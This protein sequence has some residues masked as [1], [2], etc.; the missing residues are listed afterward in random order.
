[1]YLMLKDIEVLYFNLDDFIV[2]EIRPDLV[3]FSLR[4]TFS[5]LYNMKSLMKNTQLL[6]TYLSR[7]VLS[8]SRTNAKQIYALFGIPQMDD[9][10]TR[11]KICL[12]CMGVSIQDSYWVKPDNSNLKF[13]DVNIRVN[14][15][16]E[17]IDISLDGMCPSITV[18]CINPELTTHGV[19]RKAWTRYDDG[20][21]LLK[22]DSHSQNIN[23]RMEVL[24]SKILDCFSNKI[25]CV[26]YDGRI[27]NTSYGKIYTDKCKSYAR[28]THSAVEAWEIMEYTSRQ[29]LN[30]RDYILGLS[31]KVA[32]IGV[33]DFIL[34]NTDRHTQ[35]YGFFMNNSTGLIEDVVP[36]FDFNL[37]LVSDLLGVDTSNV[38]S[39]MFNDD[40]T[41]LD[42]ARYYRPLTSIKL[43]KDKLKEIKYSNKEYSVAIDNVL[44]RYNYLYN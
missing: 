3:P 32:D 20:L 36:L 19:F 8:L 35:N 28:E 6:K 5:P 43:N 16:K 31:R 30:Y 15:F 4:G 9:I 38:I 27:R 1:M 12:A 7:R 10:E 22:S 29:G 41:L 18:S 39:Q 44:R 11:V 25:E 17:I 24:A 26:H 23:T 34:S 42:V 2:S 40:S 13:K 21:Y 14:R 37:S 33:L